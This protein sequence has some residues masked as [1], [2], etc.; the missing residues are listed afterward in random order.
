MQQLIVFGT[1]H[2]V[3]GLEKFAG[4][5]NDP[6]YKVILQYLKEKHDVD[7]MFEEAGGDGPSIASA[8]AEPGRYLDIDSQTTAEALSRFSENSHALVLEIAQKVRVQEFPTE[9]GL[10][11]QG[12]RESTWVQKIKAE[13]FKAGLLICGVAHTLS[14]V[15][16]LRREGF[17]V[18]AYIYEPIKI[19]A[20]NESQAARPQ[21][22]GLSI[23]TAGQNRWCSV[24]EKGYALF[25]GDLK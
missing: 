3:Q 25:L 9:L 23:T 15:F 10:E 11:V 14:L 8:M 5:V 24:R 22:S 18:N 21:S 17:G 20:D 1:Y 13:Q 19:W 6:N 4:S 12:W 16:R 7:F 2:N